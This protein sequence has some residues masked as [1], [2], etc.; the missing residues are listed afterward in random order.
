MKG[1]GYPRRAPGSPGGPDRGPARPLARAGAPGPDGFP[2]G[3]REGRPLPLAAVYAQDHLPD[4]RSDRMLTRGPVAVLAAGPG[5]RGSPSG[6]GRVRGAP[7]PAPG[8]GPGAVPRAPLARRRAGHRAR[9]A[10]PGKENM[11][12]ARIRDTG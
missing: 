4:V 2:G 6:P 12:Y 7:V 9:Q 1:Y 8:R 5:R 11:N 3:P 10:C